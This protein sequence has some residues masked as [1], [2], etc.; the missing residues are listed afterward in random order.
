VILCENEELLS[1]DALLARDHRSVA[2]DAGEAQ[3]V[4]QVDAALIRGINAGALEKCERLCAG[5]PAVAQCGTERTLGRRGDLVVDPE[6]PLSPRRLA[7][8]SVSRHLQ[9]PAKIC[10]RDDVESPPHGP[11]AHQL[12]AIER[13][14][15]VAE[16]HR[17]AGADGER[18]APG[19]EVLTLHGEH[20]PRGVRHRRRRSAETVRAQSLSQQSGGVHPLILPV[21]TDIRTPRVQAAGRREPQTSIGLA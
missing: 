14:V 21:N 19:G 17:A 1:A 11:A 2:D 13:R 7:A 15:D 16:R 5:A 4:Q 20:P 12:T 18:P 6:I 3:C 8:L 9:D 10:G